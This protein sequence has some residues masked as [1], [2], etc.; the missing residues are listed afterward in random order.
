M[1]L[2]RLARALLALIGSCRISY[3]FKI[4]ARLPFNIL[5]LKVQFVVLNFF[6]TSLQKCKLNRALHLCWRLTKWKSLATRDSQF[7]RNCVSTDLC[8]KDLQTPSTIKPNPR[9]RLPLKTL[10]NSLLTL[11][12]F[13]ARAW[14][15][16][17]LSLT[18]TPYLFNSKVYK[19][20][21]SCEY[22]SLRAVSYI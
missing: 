10:K 19:T 7:Y 6:Q 3:V 14:Q 8:G 2:P 18:T 4:R 12:F 11:F 22:T 13:P 21:L 16:P 5:F 17:E 9:Q 20:T 15:R 1:D